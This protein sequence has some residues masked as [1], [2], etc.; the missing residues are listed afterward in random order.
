V[1]ANTR[2]GRYCQ[3]S[4]PLDTLLLRALPTIS[5]YASEAVPA[6]IPYGLI[7][8][9]VGAILVIFLALHIDPIPYPLI[10]FAVGPVLVILFAMF[11]SRKTR[12]P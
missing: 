9:V 5:C 11:L 10:L 12:K 3:K 2:R 1:S 7:L 6:G 4:K 8:F